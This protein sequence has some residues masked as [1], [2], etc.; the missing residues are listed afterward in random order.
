M[1]AAPDRCEPLIRPAAQWYAVQTRYRFESRVAAHLQAKGLETFLPRLEEIHRWSDRRKA[2]GVSLFPGYVFVRLGSCASAVRMKV[3]R[4]QGVQ[5]FVT[6]RGEAI[7]I[8]SKQIEDL[9]LLLAHNI[10]CALHAFLKIGQRVRIRGGC[11][12]GLQGVLEH[13]RGKNLVISIDCI[14]RAIAIK[15]EGYELEPV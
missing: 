2:V 5:D 9:Q 7:P 10:P 6:F 8:P 4:T 15:I 14:Q 12:D 3:L 11:L 1:T 13:N